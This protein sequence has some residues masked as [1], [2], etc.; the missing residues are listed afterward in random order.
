MI[1]DDYGNLG[2]KRKRNRDRTNVLSQERRPYR[3]G[4]FANVARLSVEL[5]TGTEFMVIR[6][7]RKA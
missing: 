7:S 2:M 5:C 1:H 6:T 4:I 3:V